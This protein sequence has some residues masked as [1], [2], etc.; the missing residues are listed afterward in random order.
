MTQTAPSLAEQLKEVRV[1]ARPE[2]DVS[3]HVFGGDAA[4]VVTDPISFQSHRLS[5]A[6]YQVFIAIN[7]R[8]T[9]S[10]VFSG[11]VASGHLEADQEEEFYKFVLSLTQRGLL[12]L[13]LSDGG[14]LYKRFEERKEAKQ[15]GRLM[16][17]LFLRVPLVRPD[18]FLSNTM[19]LFRPLFT[20][21][22][23]GIWALCS[24]ASLLVILSRW[25]EVTSPLSS[26]LAI[27]NL[28]VLWTLL[29]VLKVIHEFGHAYAC[30]RF[31][32]EVPEMG[33][34]FILFTPCA[35]V[36][37]SA[38]WGF[39][40][41]WHRVVVALAGMYFESI[42]AMMA[43]AL[44]VLTPSGTLHDAAYYAVV[45]S[46]VVTV[47]FNAN[48]L[49]RYDGYYVLSDA[50][51]IPNLRAE[52]DKSL[53][54]VAT[55]VIYGVRGK[56]SGNGRVRSISLAVFGFAGAVYK[57]MLLLGISLVI[58]HKLPLVGFGVA[59][60]YIVQSLRQSGLSL[61]NYLRFSEELEGRRNRAIVTTVGIAVAGLVLMFVVPIPGRVESVGVVTRLDEVT[62][63]AAAPGFVREVLVECGDPIVSDEL[64]CRL[65]NIDIQ[66]EA[67]QL[68]LQT[69]ATKLRWEQELF[70][71]RQ[72][73]ARTEAMLEDLY[74]DQE[75]AEQRR[76]ALEVRSAH[77]GVVTNCES[78]Q[79]GT[80]LKR[81]DPVATVGAGPWAIRV[82]LTGEQLVDAALTPR[83]KVRIRFMG[84]PNEVFVGHVAQVASQGQTK[85]E[86]EELTHLAGGEIAVDPQSHE[87]VNPLFEVM[88]F[89]DKDPGEQ[90]RSGSTAQ[91]FFK[92]T[93]T[94]L[95]AMLYRRGLQLVNDLR[96]LG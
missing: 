78:T 63:R 91:V 58:A 1:G 93:R 50:L 8:Q 83:A 38:S 2:L 39:P 27:G 31:G 49:M 69:K 44:W 75:T 14:R 70:S 85:V 84:N 34:Y 32:G 43:L 72:S 7:A 81:G 59:L 86:R 89:L 82:L 68:E 96:M 6:D 87:S 22:A 52:A 25:D 51:G 74:E 48:P 9:L 21:V 80:F 65:E 92:G 40:S 62:V 71:N 30:K 67:Q 16:R 57:V 45:L 4:Y 64:I 94:T 90:L 60:M 56:Q 10:K 3:R 47:A 28:P 95:L 53:R 41:R 42:A 18:R 55:R 73:A 37:A 23:L 77:T 20:W 12:N 24:L 15:K 13:P 54:T 36:D 11:L 17:S 19:Y 79:V 66:S 61:L 33:A 26:I 88:V 29:I 35:Y 46:T 76:A 5:Q